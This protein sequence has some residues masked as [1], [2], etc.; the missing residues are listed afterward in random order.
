MEIAALVLTPTR[1]NGTE[2]SYKAS[3]LQIR[4]IFLRLG[5]RNVPIARFDISEFHIILQ[6]TRPSPRGAEVSSK[7]WEI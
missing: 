5:G 4:I 6:A 1:F 7:D 2:F 3:F